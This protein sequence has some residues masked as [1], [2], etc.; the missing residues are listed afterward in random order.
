MVD[1]WM[2]DGRDGRA[3]TGVWLRLTSGKTRFGT[4][5]SAL[6]ANQLI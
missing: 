2:V 3:V 6:I 4:P 5:F 1:G